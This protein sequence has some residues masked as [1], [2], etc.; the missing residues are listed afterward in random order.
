LR[1]E[2]AGAN[3]VGVARAGRANQDAFDVRRDLWAGGDLIAVVA[4]GMGGAAA[5]E[6]ASHRA[7][8]AVA[9]TTAAA[10]PLPPLP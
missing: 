1:F 7:I 4:D 5:G 6:V 9:G 10:D 3:H 8:E 2:T